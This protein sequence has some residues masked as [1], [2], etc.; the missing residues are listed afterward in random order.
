MLCASSLPSAVSP[1][2]INSRNNSVNMQLSAKHLKA[3]DTIGDGNCFYRAISSSLVGNQSQYMVLRHKIAQHLIDHGKYIFLC[4]GITSNNDESILKSA[5][6][7]RRDGTWAGEDILLV[8][9]DYLKRPIHVYNANIK[10]SPRIYLPSQPCS[11]A[12]VMIA[13]YEPGHYVYVTHSGNVYS[14]HRAIIH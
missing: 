10:D 12:P 4:A 11:D 2:V 3:V 9:A 6:N 7:V 5:V 14:P 8:A 13:F 1:T